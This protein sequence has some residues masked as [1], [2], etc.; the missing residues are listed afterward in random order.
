MRAAQPGPATV[1]T[2]L[3]TFFFFFCVL[4]HIFQIHPS[5]NGS[6]PK[7]GYRVAAA[8]KTTS[9]PR[10]VLQQTRVLTEV[11]LFLA[12]QLEGLRQFF[13]W[14]RAEGS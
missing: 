3:H 9:K 13:D 6:Q 11:H 10:E 14:M 2:T 8:L 1:T 4:L 7:A 12:Y 5:C